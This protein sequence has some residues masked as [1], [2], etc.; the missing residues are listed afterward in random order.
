MKG[1]QLL[2]FI[3][4]LTA[5]VGGLAQVPSIINYQGR[6]SA[7]GTNLFNGP[8]EFKF[9]LVNG[10]T[11][12]NWQA[13]AVATVSGGFLTII[14]VTDGGQGYGEIPAV[15]ITDPTGSNA[16]PIAHLTAG[17]V[18]SI[19]V[20]VP[21]R[22]YSPSPTVAIAPPP[23]NYA[24]VTYWSNDGSSTGGGEPGQS[25]P[26]LVNQG[27]FSVNLGDP[28]LSNMTAV[29]PP[30]IFTNSDVRL[31][32]WFS[33][34]VSAFQQ[35]YPDQQLTAA[36]YAMMAANVADGA[37]TSPKLAPGAVSIN[38]VAVNAIG[39]PN[40]ADR[41][42]TAAKLAPG[43]VGT[44]ALATSAVSTGNVA[45]GAITSSKLADASVTAA[46]LAPGVGYWVPNAI[47]V[48]TSSGTWVRPPGVNQVYVKV[49]GGG[50]AGASG[51]NA[52]GGNYYSGAGGGGGGY[53][54]A[55]ATVAG[56]ASVTV[57]SGG[58]GG[59]GG[60]SSAFLSLVAGGGTA[61]QPYPGGAVGA[62]GGA[63]G[64]S[65]NLAG[66]DGK[67]DPSNSTSKGSDGGAAALGGFGGSGGGYGYQNGKSGGF[68]GGGGG[69]GAS[70]FAGG[71]GAGGLVIVYY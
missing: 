42:I 11:N 45:D 35:F 27:L 31:R 55:V 43:A 56:D 29:I 24:Y 48:F 71:S 53:C 47:A 14:T 57:G 44:S 3:T 49:W 2:T 34:G 26:L 60:G 12:V 10:G 50:G 70:V 17:V 6:L 69:G 68:P 52:G 59:S 51:Y 36:G 13:T 33:D 65:I 9:A 1:I 28:G 18:T 67:A 62:G 54:E 23:P 61:A 22:N 40:I 4:A 39:T 5:A 64:G 8:G 63:S 46:K 38:A 7:G 30:S 21:G 32:I 58:T 25:V 66:Q 37:I 20:P 41:S 19:T 16:V 15:T